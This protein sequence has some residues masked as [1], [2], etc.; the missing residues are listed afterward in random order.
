[1]RE[2]RPPEHVGLVATA[3]MRCTTSTLPSCVYTPLEHQPT[4]SALVLD[5]R[6]P[7]GF[8]RPPVSP[9]VPCALALKHPARAA[10]CAAVPRVHRDFAAPHSPKRR[11]ILQDLVSEAL[12]ALQSHCSQ[13]RRGLS[14]LRFNS[15]AP[16]SWRLSTTNRAARCVAKP[17]VPSILSRLCPRAQRCAS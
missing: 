3:I 15:C 9:R 17:C 10:C 12:C 16:R 7:L 2:A 4:S 11:Q 6:A 1:M 8:K 5:L 14:M 13:Q